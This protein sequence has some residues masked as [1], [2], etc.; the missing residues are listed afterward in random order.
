M[1]TSNINLMENSASLPLEKHL[2]C[3]V[4][5]HALVWPEKWSPRRSCTRT[6]THPGWWWWWWWRW[7]WRMRAWVLLSTLAQGCYAAWLAVQWFPRG[8]CAA[9]SHTAAPAAIF[10]YESRP[11]PR[12]LDRPEGNA[13]RERRRIRRRKAHFHKFEKCQREVQTSLSTS[14]QGPFPAINEES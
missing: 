6:Q 3:S 5:G 1:V 2:W 4:W 9:P 14:N 11:G 13:Q 10:C 7:V 8:E 12:S